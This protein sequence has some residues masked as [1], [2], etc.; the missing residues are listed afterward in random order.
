MQIKDRTNI[1]S[2]VHD[3]N[4]PDSRNAKALYE[5]TYRGS[6]MYVSRFGRDPQE[7]KEGRQAEFFFYFFISNILKECVNNR[8]HMFQNSILFFIQL[9][10]T[11]IDL[12]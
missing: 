12:M 3:S 1:L 11:L 4:L 9:S 6:L 7:L 10:H 2:P 5:N 8:P